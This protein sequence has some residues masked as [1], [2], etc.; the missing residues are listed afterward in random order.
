MDGFWIAF[1]VPSPDSKS[2]LAH[3][4]REAVRAAFPEAGE[5]DIQLDR[6]KN[7][8]HG[9]LTPNLAPPLAQRGGRQPRQAAEAIVAPPRRPAR[10]ARAEDAGPGLLHPPP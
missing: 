6:P 4:V 3:L 8:A 5:V 7:P 10:I 2:R 9:D 1:S